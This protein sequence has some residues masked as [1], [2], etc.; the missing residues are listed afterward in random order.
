ML[1]RFLVIEKSKGYLCAVAY[2]DGFTAAVFFSYEMIEKII[3]TSEGVD[4]EGPEPVHEMLCEA[5]IVG[6]EK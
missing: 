4:I 2:E 6:V 3:N 5:I 1:T